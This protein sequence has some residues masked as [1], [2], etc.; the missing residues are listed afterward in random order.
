MSWKLRAQRLS[1]GWRRSATWALPPKLL[2]RSV[3]D[4]VPISDARMSGQRW[5]LQAYMS[6]CPEA[7]AE[8]VGASFRDGDVI[9]A[10]QGRRSFSSLNAT[11]RSSPFHNHSGSLQQF[12]E[13][14]NTNSSMSTHVIPDPIPEPFS[15]SCGLPWPRRFH[16]SCAL[17][18]TGPFCLPGDLNLTP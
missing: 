1:A 9:R 7:A 10:R 16:G 3:T 11:D 17:W 15:F 12:H 13:K 5:G 14:I 8:D 18:S 4:M 2:R 6:L